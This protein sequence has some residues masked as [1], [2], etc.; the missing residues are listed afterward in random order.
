MASSRWQ[1]CGIDSWR[2]R[3]VSKSRLSE[4]TCVEEFSSSSYRDRR[5]ADNLKRIELYRSE[6]G[7]IQPLLAG[8]RARRWNSVPQ[9]GCRIGPCDSFGARVGP[10]VLARDALAVRIWKHITVIYKVVLERHFAELWVALLWFARGPRAQ[11]ARRALGVAPGGG[12]RPECSEAAIGQARGQDLW[13][14]SGEWHRGLCAGCSS[15]DVQSST[16]AF[17]ILGR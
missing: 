7:K 13:P 16:W 5:I 4:G 2:S 3:S 12:R 10:A 6:F 15:A 9:S 1:L 17:E 8:I 14:G 11:A